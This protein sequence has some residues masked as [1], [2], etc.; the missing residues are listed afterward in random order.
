MEKIKILPCEQILVIAP[1]PDDESIGCGGLLLKY[2]KQC[3]VICLTD[4]RQGQ[5]DITPIELAQIRKAEFIKVMNK[6]GVASYNIG[7]IEDGTL[8]VHLDCLRDIDFSKYSKVFVT[9]RNDQHPDHTAALIALKRAIKN[10]QID[11]IEVFEYEVHRHLKNPTHYFYVSQVID[12]KKELIRLYDSQIKNV[13]FDAIAEKMNLENGGNIEYYEAYKLINILSVDEDISADINLQKMREFYWLFA[14]W[15]RLENHSKRLSD[16][17]LQK[18]INKVI[19]YGYKEVGQLVEDGLL[20]DGVKVVG[21]IDNNIKLRNKYPEKI[22][23]IEEGLDNGYQD[24]TILVT[25]TFYYEDI[26][27]KVE[28]YGYKNVLSLKSIIEEMEYLEEPHV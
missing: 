18:K 9:G 20:R 8:C 25:A 11:T 10:Q 14:R 3:D 4:G 17:L 28:K 22:I 15:M 5:G 1:H 24:I 19:I 2:G 13:P 21:I 23:N 12:K 6:V 26:K 7:A 16:Y 27:N